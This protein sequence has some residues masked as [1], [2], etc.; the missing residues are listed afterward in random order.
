VREEPIHPIRINETIVKPMNFTKFEAII[1]GTYGSTARKTLENSLETSSIR[2]IDAHHENYP[3]ELSSRSKEPQ[4]AP[5]RRLCHQKLMI[6]P[7]LEIES[8]QPMFD[9]RWKQ[10][11]DSLAARSRSRKVEA[12]NKMRQ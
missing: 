7:L 5:I 10:R 8:C 3:E 11:R 9:E 6:N 12:F 1:A 2:R 4:K